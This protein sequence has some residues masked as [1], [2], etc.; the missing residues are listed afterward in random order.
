MPTQASEIAVSCVQMEPRIGAVRENIEKSVAMAEQAAERGAELVVLPELCTSGYVF[1]SLAEA[2]A[3]AEDPQDG[4]SVRAWTALAARRRL[5]L[6]AGLNERADG[7]IYNSAVV[8]GP[9][10]VLGVFRKVHL[11][12][13]ENE[14]F[15]RGDLGFPIF[16]LPFGR[17]DVSIC[18]DGWFPESYRMCALQVP[19]WSACQPTGFPCRTSRRT[20]R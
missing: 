14:F 4:P 17:I 18:Y 8:I 13:M 12:D 11:W 5:H 3:L 7:R 9:Q 10:G 2:T 16:D 19:G 15:T 6:V 1:D 20:G